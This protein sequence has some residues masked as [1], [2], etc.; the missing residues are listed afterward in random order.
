LKKA[1]LN[2]RPS[3]YEQ[4]KKI[5]TKLLE[6]AW[7]EKDIDHLRL[8]LTDNNSPI[9]SPIKTTAHRLL[10]LLKEV[11]KLEGNPHEVC[12]TKADGA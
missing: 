7:L 3:F 6:I 1:L 4:Q 12:N 5:C 8:Y 10:N 2:L 9:K 11:F